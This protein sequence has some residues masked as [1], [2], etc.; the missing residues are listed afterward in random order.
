MGCG[1]PGR[2]FVL[3]GKYHSEARVGEVAGTKACLEVFISGGAQ[4]C[5]RL[6]PHDFG[7]FFFRE[8]LRELEVI[9]EQEGFPYF[10]YGESVVYHDSD[11]GEQSAVPTGTV[12]HAGEILAVPA[13]PQEGRNLADRSGGVCL[14][15][16]CALYA[17]YFES[18]DL[19]GDAVVC[20]K[21][22]GCRRVDAA[23]PDNAI[24]IGEVQMSAACR[25]PRSI[26]QA[27]G[28]GHFQGS[29]ESLPFV[30]VNRHPAGGYFAAIFM[31]LPCFFQRADMRDS[32][33]GF[34]R[35][36]ALGLEICTEMTVI[37]RQGAIL[38]L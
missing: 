4:I 27:E 8:R 7:Q 11:M 28:I 30:E 38:S 1:V 34:G 24:C 15:S 23:F 25:L 10:L 20:R 12:H 32:L 9:Y 13:R 33:M 36:L 5:E 2:V 3:S 17:V 37:H 14:A 6:V 19:P 22:S 29:E 31:E 18:D 16:I 21:A 26:V 35:R